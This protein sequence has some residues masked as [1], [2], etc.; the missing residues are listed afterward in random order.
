MSDGVGSL[1]VMAVTT[2]SRLTAD[3]FFALPGEQKHTQLIDGE[4]IVNAPSRRHQ[5]ILGY[6][7]VR[8]VNFVEAHPGTGEAGLEVDIPVDEFN[9]YVPDIW[10]TTPEHTL[11]REA[12]RADGPP[13]LIAEIRSPGTWSK[14]KGIKKDRYEA[15]GLP[16]LWLVDTE[17]DTV[18][19][20]RRSRPACESFDVSFEVGGGDTLTT[21][22]IPGFALDLTAL[23]DR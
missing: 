12:L 14:D 22:L 13:D 17:A 2:R 7:L 3:E 11:P 18:I 9:V 16:E 20:F 23:F 19:V 5:R 8:L 1:G 21:P 15:A 4:I 10:W 6:L